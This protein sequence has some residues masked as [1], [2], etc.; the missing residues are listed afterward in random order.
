MQTKS[1]KKTLQTTEY[2]NTITIKSIKFE[3]TCYALSKGYF[4]F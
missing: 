2:A 1:K 4:F 3:D